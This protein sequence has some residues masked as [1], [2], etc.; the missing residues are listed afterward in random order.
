MTTTIKYKTLSSFHISGIDF[1]KTVNVSTLKFMEYG[2]MCTNTGKHEHM[3][4]LDG[5]SVTLGS[6]ADHP[7]T[8]CQAMSG[9]ES[10]R[11]FRDKEMA[12]KQKL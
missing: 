5:S 3:H 2:L 8:M 7:A 11:S 4:A 9:L 1:V 6:V 10:P 12:E